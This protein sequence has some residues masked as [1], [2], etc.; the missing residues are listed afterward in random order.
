M[1]FCEI[2]ECRLAA[3]TLPPVGE[4]PPIHI[5]EGCLKELFDKTMA[6]RS[7]ATVQ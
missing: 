1:K 3:Y 5:C 6:E 2:C 4:T 7:T